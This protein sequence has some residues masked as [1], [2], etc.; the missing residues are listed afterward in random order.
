[1]FC[2]KQE[3]TKTARTHARVGQESLNLHYQ[4]ATGSVRVAYDRLPVRTD[5]RYSQFDKNMRSRT[6][7]LLLF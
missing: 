1:M 2:A 6:S 4:L 3:G 7:Q 5:L